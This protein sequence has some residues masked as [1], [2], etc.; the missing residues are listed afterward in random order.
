MY[1]SEIKVGESITEKIAE[2]I[3]ESDLTAVVLSHNSV[4]S[5]WVKRELQIAINKEMQEK[6]VVVLPILLEKVEFPGFLK[7]KEYADFTSSDKYQAAFKK[8]FAALGIT[9]KPGELLHTVQ[10]FDEVVGRDKIPSVAKLHTSAGNLLTHFVDIKIIDLDDKRP[11]GCSAR[12]CTTC[13]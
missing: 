12:I 6:R 4:D 2:G 9:Q 3:Q 1:S 8:L 11:F 10:V 13:I 5:V 7:D